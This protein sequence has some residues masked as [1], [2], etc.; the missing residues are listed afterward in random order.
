M[1]QNGTWPRHMCNHGEGL[2]TGSLANKSAA[3]WPAR[4]ARYGHKTDGLQYCWPHPR[5]HTPHAVWEKHGATA[6]PDQ[7]SNEKSKDLA[8]K[9]RPKFQSSGERA[10]G[11]HTR[12]AR[13]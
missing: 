10:R 6:P 3:W 9:T 2:A 12:C 11:N 13:C 7:L 4:S 5:V 8:G 1:A